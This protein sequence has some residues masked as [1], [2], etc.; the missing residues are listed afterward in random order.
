[1]INCVKSVN[2][3]KDIGINRIYLMSFLTGLVSFLFLYLPFSMAHST[4][5]VKDHGFLPLVIILFFLPA[6]HRLMHI[7][8]LLLTNKRLRM[9]FKFKR[10]LIPT[11][12]YQCKSTLSKQTSLLMALSPTLFITLPGLVMGYVLP[13]YFAY[14]VL[15]SAVNIGLSFSDFLYIHYFMKAP[16]KC[17]IEN[18][19][20]GYDILVQQKNA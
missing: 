17:I 20:E 5:D 8:P 15:F 19:K 6:I 3:N 4:H 2:I 1:M 12:V 7:V 11:F 9:K 18:A 10:R 13:D 16:R 14:F